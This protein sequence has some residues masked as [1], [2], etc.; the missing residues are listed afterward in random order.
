[1]YLNHKLAE[2]CVWNEWELGQCSVTCAGGTRIDTRTKTTEARYGGSCDSMGHQRE[3]HCN[4][5]KCPRKT[6]I[7]IILI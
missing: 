4:T 5:H 2:P 3:E 1:M 7:K 6:I